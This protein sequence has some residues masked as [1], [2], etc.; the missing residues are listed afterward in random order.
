MSIASRPYHDTH[1]L[2]KI[3]AATA[4]WIASVGFCGYL[5]VGDLVLRLFNG[6]RRYDPREIV[7]LW[8]DTDGS[9]LGWGMI[10]PRWNSYDALLH[11]AHRGDD[12]EV[13]L[14]AWCEQTAFTWM[15][16]EGRF[17]SPISLDVFVEDINRIMVLEQW[18]YRRGEQHHVIG[19]RSL[20]ESIP[21]VSLPQGFTVR[22]IEGLHEVDK[23]IEA[24][25]A[26]F[27]WNWTLEDFLQVM[28]SP[29][30][31]VL[32]P[33]VIVAP[34]GR[35]TSFCYLM[36]DKRNKIGMFEDVGTHPDFQ[37]RGLGRALLYAGLKRLKAQGMV[38]AYMP[39]NSS[40]EAASSLYGSVGFRVGFRHIQ[41]IKTSPIGDLANNEVPIG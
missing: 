22:P 17:E 20:D 28:Q 37:R 3:Q 29:A 41:Y 6:M 8:E 30:Y 24:Q 38:T 1:D 21:D 13:Q 36:L 19:L 34:G 2:H 18:G 5:H 23:L 40:L 31:E 39:Y 11:P 9:L 15:R 27:G 33:F 4:N 26:S 14:L 7:R 16:R 32:E 10:Y 35:F 25:N 12:L